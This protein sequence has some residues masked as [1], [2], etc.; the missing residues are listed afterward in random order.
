MKKIISILAT[1][2][3]VVIMAGSG[4]AN[5]SHSARVPAPRPGTGTV[6]PDGSNG[7]IGTVLELFKATGISIGL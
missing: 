7:L 2:Y 6:V 5:E 1:A 3:L 4:F